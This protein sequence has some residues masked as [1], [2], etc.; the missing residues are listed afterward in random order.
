MTSSIEI[1]QA[2]SYLS[3]LELPLGSIHCSTTYLWS[4]FSSMKQ[5]CAGE[6]AYVNSRKF[7]KS[8]KKPMAIGILQ[9]WPIY[10]K[11]YP[12]L[13]RT[14][15]QQSAE[16]WMNHIVK[17]IPKVKRLKLE[18]IKHE[19]ENSVACCYPRCVCRCGHSVLPE[20]LQ[21]PRKLW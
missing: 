5:L 10:E 6:E 14:N 13:D 11:M 7:S 17:K 9:L 19:I 1:H 3:R 8:K 20:R 21:R 15:P 16:A 12:G 18:Q 4:I 2:S